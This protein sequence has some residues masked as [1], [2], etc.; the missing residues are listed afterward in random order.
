MTLEEVL[1]LL[2]VDKIEGNPQEL[3]ELI[4]ATESLVKDHGK[5]WITQNRGR[6]LEEWEYILRM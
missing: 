2:Q 5:E 1:E 6:L 3:Q 4:E